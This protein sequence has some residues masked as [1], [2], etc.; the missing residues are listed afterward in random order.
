MIALDSMFPSGLRETGPFARELERLGFQGLW[1]NETPHEPF[2]PILAAALT[3]ERMTLGTGIA[4]A[5]TRSPMIT[6]LT[7]WDLQ[8]ASNGRFVLG[9]GTQVKAHNARRY[10]APTPAPGRQLRELILALR[11]VWEVFQGEHPLN[12][13]GD[14]YTLDLMTPMHSPGPIA[15][16]YI[17]IYLAAVGPFTY[18]LAGELADGVHVHSFHTVPY[19]REVAL[20]ALHRGLIE[21]GR[22]RESITLVCSLFAIV[23]GDPAMDRAVRSQIAFYGSTSA[24]RPIFD[25]HGWGHLTDQLKLA[26]RSGDVDA[27]VAAI[28]DEVVEAFA[29]VADNWQD[30]ARVVEQRYDGILDRVGFYALH[31]M[32]DISRAP[33]IAAAFT[34]RNVTSKGVI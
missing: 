18:R 28:D 21:A 25:V 17:P 8:Q 7:A 15:H 30:V 20:P 33:D 32:V 5:F 23:G 29:V 22:E 27:M 6:A 11:H 12:F 26:V 19:L 1:T 31:G 16:P 34:R 13:H 14:F 24:Y 10:S 2:L 9:L 4:T 3:T